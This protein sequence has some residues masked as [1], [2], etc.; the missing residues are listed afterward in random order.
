MAGMVSTMPKRAHGAVVLDDQHVG[1]DHEL[2]QHQDERD[3]AA[4]EGEAREGVGRQR[5]QHEL[6]GEDHGD[7]QEGV[8]E[9]ARER[10]GVPG[11]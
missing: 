7:E 3:I 11:A 6:G 4:G 1:H 5:A 2:E 10:R 8:E 9:I